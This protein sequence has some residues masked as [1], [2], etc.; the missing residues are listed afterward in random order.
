MQSF[1]RK[2]TEIEINEC[3]VDIVQELG[4]SEL[5]KRIHKDLI[6]SF[7]YMNEDKFGKSFYDYCKI[8]GSDFEDYKYRSINTEFGEII[9]SIRFLGGDLN[10]PFVF[11][12]HKDFRIDSEKQIKALGKILKEEYKLFKPQRIRWY[13]PDTEIFFDNKDIKGDLIYIYQFINR[14]KKEEFPSN[15]DKVRLKNA[16]SLKWYKEYQKNYENLNQINPEFIEMAGMESRQT[17]RRLMKKGLLFEIMIDNQWAGIIAADKSSEKY[18]KGYVI[19]EEL[20]TEKFRGRH[21]ATAVQRHLIEKLGSDNQEML[22]GTI[23][24]QN[25]PSQKTAYKAG[26]KKAGSYIFAKIRE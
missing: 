7:R 15:F 2:W 3:P 25:T 11:I 18:F 20:L 6:Q 19:F 21:F 4:K 16:D 14:L 8:A 23:H 9:S 17:F 24:A 22:Y 26:R 13:S 12:V 1:I 5:K 10:K